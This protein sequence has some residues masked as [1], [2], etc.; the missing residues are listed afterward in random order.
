MISFH[1]YQTLRYVGCTLYDH[2]GEGR[3]KVQSVPAA[4]MV[5][6]GYQKHNYEKEGR[7]RE[8]DMGEG[9]GPVVSATYTGIYPTSFIRQL[10]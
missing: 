5:S 3:M 7:C 4:H 9:R 6:L 8:V 1:S 10:H 2:S